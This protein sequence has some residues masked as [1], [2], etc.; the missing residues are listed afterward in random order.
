MAKEDEF[1]PFAATGKHK[2]SWRE[3]RTWKTFVVVASYAVG[4]CV[5]NCGPNAL[6]TLSRAFDAAPQENPCHGMKDVEDPEMIWGKVSDSLT[7]M[8]HRLF[9]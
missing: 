8:S 7:F 3:T 2:V 1:V 9:S 5:L 4:L 6:N